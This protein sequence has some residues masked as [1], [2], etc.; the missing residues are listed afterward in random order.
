LCPYSVNI[1]TK[2]AEKNTLPTR[3]DHLSK[4]ICS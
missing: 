3:P 2:G 1:T 4:R